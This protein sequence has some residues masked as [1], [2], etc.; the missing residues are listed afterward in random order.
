M[1]FDSRMTEETSEHKD[2]RFC[3][4]CGSVKTLFQPYKRKDGTVSEYPHWI[5]DDKGGWLCHKCHMKYVDNIRRFTFRDK[6]LKAIKRPHNGICAFCGAKKGDIYSKT[7][8]PV[9]THIAHIQYHDDAPLEDTIEL[10]GSCHIKYDKGI[11]PDRKCC[12]CKGSKT[13]HNHAGYPYWRK[14]TSKDGGFLCSK[15]YNKLWRE[16]HV[17]KSS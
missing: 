13:Y 9:K 14:S 16:K 12:M 4:K 8:Q 17:L 3:S 15:C 10:C 6:Q 11:P 2:K 7:G 5:R 1:S